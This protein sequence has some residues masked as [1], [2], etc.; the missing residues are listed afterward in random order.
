MKVLEKGECVAP[1][2]SRAFVSVCFFNYS[3]VTSHPL[4]HFLSHKYETLPVVITTGASRVVVEMIILH[5]VEKLQ[6]IK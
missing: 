3:Y 1:D 5:T 2:Y 6:N 4:S